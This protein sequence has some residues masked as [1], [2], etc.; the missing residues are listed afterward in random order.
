[1]TKKNSSITG[2]CLII[3][4]LLTYFTVVG[5]GDP[6]TIETGFDNVI[7]EWFYSIRSPWLTEVAK[8]VT[9]M[10]N[11]KT[12]IA[13]C[14]LLLIIPSVTR[15]IGIPIAAVAIAGSAINKMFKH[16]IMRPRPDVS[17]HLIEQG[18][19][20]FPS[21]HSISS[22]L[23][24]GF[25]AWLIIRYCKNQRIVNIATVVLTLLWIGVGLSRIY[26]GVHYPTD[27]L[28]GWTL[29]MVIMMIAITIIE[30]TQKKD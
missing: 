7:R 19:W 23:M 29:G 21:G 28:G 13:I 24:Y 20:S 16:I 26:L 27:V 25:L 2:L 11:T 9:F 14:I 10:G 18:G 3:F 15:K 30:R 4:I 12:I 17:L 8:A 1:M 6:D 5:Q 22:L